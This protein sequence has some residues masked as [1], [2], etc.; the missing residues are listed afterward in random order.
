MNQKENGLL[1]EKSANSN[2]ADFPAQFRVI[3]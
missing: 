2:D 3:R 1:I